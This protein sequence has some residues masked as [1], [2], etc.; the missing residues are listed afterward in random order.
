MNAIERE[1]IAKESDIFDLLQIL[2]IHN[3]VHTQNFRSFKSEVVH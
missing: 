2:N 1:L 3:K